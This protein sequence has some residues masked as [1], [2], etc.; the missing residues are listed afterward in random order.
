M[1]CRRRREAAAQQ[2]RDPG[3]G[4]A[5]TWQPPGRDSHGLLVPTPLRISPSPPAGS[6]PP[7]RSV[8]VFY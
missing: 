7:A 6:A 8:L 5:R 4:T 1:G 3:P 2:L